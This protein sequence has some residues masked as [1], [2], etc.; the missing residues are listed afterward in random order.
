MLTDEVKV[1]RKSSWR[2]LHKTS[3]RDIPR[4]L[5]ELLSSKGSL[6]SR[7]R[8]LC[9]ESFNV[10]VLSQKVRLPASDELTCLRSPAGRW[11]LVREVVLRCNDTPLVFARTVIPLAT[12]TGAHRRLA[13]L[14]SRP[15]GEV[16]FSD[17][18]MTRGEIEVAGFTCTMPA[19]CANHPGHV[20]G[21]RSV[22]YLGHK[23]LLVSEI[24]ISGCQSKS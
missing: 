6:T 11:M 20:W 24:F 8:L 23:P 18:C 1:V 17:P 3:R 16:L 12:L 15:L 2:L 10:Q 22:F 7:L 21:R 4:G 5:Y 19:A 14:G 13:S 9:G